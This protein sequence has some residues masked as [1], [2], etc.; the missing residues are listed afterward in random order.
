VSSPERPPLHNHA[1]A[2][3]AQILKIPLAEILVGLALFLSACTSISVTRVHSGIALFWPANAIA[4]AL[5]IRLPRVRWSI[6]VVSVLLA[7]VLANVI[8]AHRPWPTAALFACVHG[9]EI[10]LMV[11]AFRF[12]WMFPYP[13]ITINH[14]AFMTALFGIT[15]PGLAALVAGLVLRNQLAASFGDITLQWWSSHAIGACLLGPPIILFSVKELKRLMQGRFFAEN[16]L[17]CLVCLAGCYLVVRYVR[18]PFVGI[19]LLLLIAAF[20][21]GGFGTSMLSLALGL[22]ITNLWLVGVRPLGLDPLAAASQSLEGLPVLAFLASLMPAIAVGLGSDAR[23]AAGRALRASERRFRESMEHS[24]IGMLI[25]DLNG[26]W[27]YTNIALQQM[28]GYTAEEF[29]ALPPGGPSKSE[30]WQKSKTRWGRLLTGEINVYEVTRSFRHKEGHW[31]WTHVAVSLLRDEDGLPLNLISQIESLEARQRAEK[32]IAE[33]RERLKI[34]LASINDAV[35]TTDAQTR[36]TYLNAAGEA[37]LGL[38]MGAVE[39]RRFDEVIILVDPQTS[40][41][42]ASLIG[43]SVLHGKV[44]KRD[45][46]CLL[47]RSDGTVCYVTDTV[48]PVLGTTGQVNGM[49][50]V[51]RDA[52][53]EID[54]ARDLQYRATHD[55]LTR[56]CN[57]TEFENRLNSIFAAARHLNRPAAVLAIDLDRFKALND[58]GGH[59]AGDAMLQKVAEACCATVRS[60]DTV[61]RLGGDEFAILLDN[62]SEGRAN[63]IGRQLMKALNSL[64]IQWAGAHY[65]IGASIGLATCTMEMVDAKAWLQAADDACYNAKRGGRGQLRS[66]ASTQDNVGARKP[67]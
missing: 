61:A 23:R 55:P 41:A 51:L 12:I 45:Q 21:L 67:S 48:S 17:T 63:L 14:A 5:L 10:A 24:P 7:A 4:A 53:L 38:D 58:A 34:T 29:R 11:L 54:R 36:I 22:L 28:L 57:R 46:A 31:I 32:T 37:L 2:A 30:E 49:V 19:G 35:I 40:K 16:V 18:F 59:A 42:A 3:G 33:E 65:S 25:A 6:A 50:I 26:V 15:I 44:F 27:G 52:T 47:H 9:S 13:R 1:E 56:L 8:A 66:A 60:S 20:R 43:R 62:C 39:T 64:E